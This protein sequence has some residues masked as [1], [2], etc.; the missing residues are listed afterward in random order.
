MFW[1]KKSSYISHRIPNNVGDREQW[2]ALHD[3]AVG[4]DLKPSRRLARII[5]IIMSIGILYARSKGSRPRNRAGGFET[6]PYGPKCGR[7]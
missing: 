7:S 1:L 4:K 6:L 5:G 2:M 3:K